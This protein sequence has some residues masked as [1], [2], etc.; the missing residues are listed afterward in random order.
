[1]DHIY[2][3]RKKNTP[4]SDPV[5][6]LYTHEE[7]IDTIQS[8]AEEYNRL[9][10]IEEETFEEKYKENE[11]VEERKE[12]TPVEEIKMIDEEIVE[13]VIEETFESEETEETEETGGDEGQQF[14]NLPTPRKHVLITILR[15]VMISMTQTGILIGILH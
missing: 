14:W 7:K 11:T 5:P 6:P 4:P 2:S 1:M 15:L 3:N 8:R 13:P 10:A 12:E 9:T